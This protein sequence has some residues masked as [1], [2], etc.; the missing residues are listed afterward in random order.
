[1]TGRMVPYYRPEM[2]INQFIRIYASSSP[3]IEKKNYVFRVCAELNIL[4]STIIKGQIFLS[5]KKIKKMENALIGGLVTILT[6]LLKKAP[7]VPLNEGQ[8]GKIKVFVVLISLLCVVAMAY[9]TGDLTNSRLSY[10]TQ[11]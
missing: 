6:Q 10:M 7:A 11:S 5:A 3:E 1:M 2:T 9:V 4:P 8:K